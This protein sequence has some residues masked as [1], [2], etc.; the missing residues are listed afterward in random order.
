MIDAGKPLNVYAGGLWQPVRFPNINFTTKTAGLRS[1]RRD[2]HQGASV[3]WLG[4]GENQDGPL[5]CD[6]TEINDPNFALAWVSR[7]LERP[8]IFCP[9][10]RL[11]EGGQVPW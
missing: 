5:F 7:H 11:K 6:H 1:K 4:I 3:V 8:P 10:P 2:N 9:A